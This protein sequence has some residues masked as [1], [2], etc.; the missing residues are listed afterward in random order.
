MTIVKLWLLGTLSSSFHLPSLWRFCYLNTLLSIFSMVQ[1]IRVRLFAVHLSLVCFERASIDPCRMTEGYVLNKVAVC[2]RHVYVTW[3]SFERRILLLPGESV[4]KKKLYQRCW[5][6]R[7][8]GCGNMV[9]VLMTSI[10]IPDYSNYRYHH[11]SV[12]RYY[13]YA[14]TKTASCQVTVLCPYLFGLYT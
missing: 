10:T 2:S 8:N 9:Y 6:L 12:H 4:Y 13:Y 5:A 3:G 7:V 1:T 14:I 11:C